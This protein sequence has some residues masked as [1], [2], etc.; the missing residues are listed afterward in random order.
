RCHANVF[1]FGVSKCGTTSLAHWMAEHPELRWVSNPE[2]HR[3]HRRGAEAHV[4]EMMEKDDF[5]SAVYPLTAPEASRT[6]PVVDYTPHYSILA[7]VPYRIEGMYGKSARDG[8]FKYVVILR[9]PVAR[10]ISSWQFK[11]DREYFRMARQQ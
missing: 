6:D 10:T 3:H 11:Y 9:E 4:I 5:A 7:E 8:S 1:L 2:V